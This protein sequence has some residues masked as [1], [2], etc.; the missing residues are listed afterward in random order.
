MIEPRCVWENASFLFGV[1][2]AIDI[3]RPRQQLNKG[4]S[5]FFYCFSE[6]NSPLMSSSLLLCDKFSLLFFF[7]LSSLRFFVALALSF[8][9][10]CLLFFFIVSLFLSSVSKPV[11]ICCRCLSGVLSR[12]EHPICPSQCAKAQTYQR[13][14]W[15]SLLCEKQ[16]EE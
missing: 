11:E 10:L 7:P 3:G 9:L 1:W 8:S 13:Q 15:H 4:L 6:C 5:V 16:W 12:R 14:K 2:D